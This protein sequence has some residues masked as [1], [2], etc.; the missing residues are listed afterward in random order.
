MNIYLSSD[1]SRNFK[2]LTKRNNELRQ[3]IKEKIKLFEKNPR[4]PSLHLHKL[5]GK[6]TESWSISIEADLRI[7]L[8]YVKDGILLID[9]GKHEEVY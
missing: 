4:Y 3:K 2:K 7:V 6:E 5:I 9:I 8:Q 1:F